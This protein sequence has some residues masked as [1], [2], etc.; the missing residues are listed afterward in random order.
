MIIQLV[1]MVLSLII[2]EDY[3]Y[4]YYIRILL[5]III[6][7]IADNS[8]GA[9]ACRRMSRAEITITV[10]SVFRISCLFLRPRLWQLEI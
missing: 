6:I 8:G 1:I 3:I 10:R 9:L 5:M 2:A 4:Y 7:I